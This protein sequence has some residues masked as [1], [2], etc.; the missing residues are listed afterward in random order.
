MIEVGDILREMGSNDIMWVATDTDYEEVRVARYGK[1]VYS[2]YI[3]S[4]VHSHDEIR[5]LIRDGM[6]NKVGSV[7]TDGVINLGGDDWYSMDVE[8]TKNVYNSIEDSGERPSFDDGI[9]WNAHE[10]K[11]LQV[12]SVG[13]EDDTLAD[14]LIRFEDDSVEALPTVAEAMKHGILVFMTEPREEAIPA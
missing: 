2:H 5:D 4:T 7:E 1:R 10:V 11:S 9:F 6:V 14:E 13:W 12:K 8:R 3:E